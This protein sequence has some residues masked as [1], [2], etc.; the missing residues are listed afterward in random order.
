MSRESVGPENIGGLALFLFVTPAVVEPGVTAL[1]AVMFPEVAD[2]SPVGRLGTVVV[3]IAAAVLAV[4]GAVLALRRTS[5]LPASVVA[6][7]LSVASG[8]LALTAFFFLF[9]GGALL[10]L[11]VLLVH[12]VFSIVMIVRAVTRSRPAGVER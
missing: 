6:V 5:G 7:L 9:S 8:L 10:I 2:A 4:A 11:A 12:A 3:G 1:A